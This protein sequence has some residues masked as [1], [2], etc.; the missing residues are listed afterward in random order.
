MHELV[1][2]HVEE[3]L[4]AKDR[5]FDDDGGHRRDDRRTDQAGVQIADDFFE[6]KENR[7]HRRVELVRTPADPSGCDIIARTPSSTR[8]CRRSA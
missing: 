6:R 5:A 7:G 3:R 2:R 4:I 1:G 8:Q